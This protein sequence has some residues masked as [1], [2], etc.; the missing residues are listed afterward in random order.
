MN[1]EPLHGHQDLNI[2]EKAALKLP[3]ISGYMTKEMARDSDQRIRGYFSDRITSI[4]EE[5][6]GFQRRRTDQGRLA[7]LDK[8]ERIN[9]KLDRLRDTIRYSARGYSGLFDGIKVNEDKLNQ[10]YVFDLKLKSHIDSM[11]ESFKILLSKTGKTADLDSV[12]DE[13][14]SIAD[15]FQQV[16]DQRKHLLEEGI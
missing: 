14:E 6:H 2:L 9:M 7:G 5:L 13:M 10:L 1:N 11:A 8:L 4:K 16:I 15:N 12:A 3:G